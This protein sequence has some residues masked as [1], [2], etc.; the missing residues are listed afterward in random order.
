MLGETLP[1]AIPTELAHKGN[2]SAGSLCGHG[3]IGSLATASGLQSSA[4]DRFTPLW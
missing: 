2:A 1:I 4:K 3:L